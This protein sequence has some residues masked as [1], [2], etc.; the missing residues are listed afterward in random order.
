[1]TLLLWLLALL[2]FGLGS[3]SSSS[4]SA[5]PAVTV[6]A[7]AGAAGTCS[8][9]QLRPRVELQGAAGSLR[10]AVEL[11]NVGEAC[12]LDVVGLGIDG[13][14]SGIDVALPPRPPLELASGAGA[15]LS[16]V[17]RNW[18]GG[19]NPRLAVE[20]G[21]RGRVVVPLADTPRCDDAGAPSLLD[22][23]APT[24]AP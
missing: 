19:P 7:P 24:P 14:S 2:L 12:V 23:G 8:T 5:A 18:C 15:S 17:W 3:G 16:V 10:G 21:A 4:T 20:L 1:V 9:G 13:D 11:R 6:P 22:V